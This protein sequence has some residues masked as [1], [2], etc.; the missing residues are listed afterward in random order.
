MAKGRGSSGGGGNHRSARTG[1]YVTEAH[2]RRSPGTTVREA[3]GASGDGSGSH[4]RSAG[5]GRYVTAKHGKASPDT[6]VKES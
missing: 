3:P 1:R 4:Y 6:T 2:G 5:T